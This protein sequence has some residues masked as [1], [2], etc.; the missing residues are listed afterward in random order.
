MV[1]IYTIYGFRFHCDLHLDAL[2]K[3]SDNHGIIDYPEIRIMTLQSDISPSIGCFPPL[4][5]AYGHFFPMTDSGLFVYKDK[6]NIY[7]TPRSLEISPQSFV[8]QRI[9]HEIC[10]ASLIILS[11]FHHRAVLHGS[12]VCY[13]GK[14][15]LFCALPGFGKSTLTAAFIAFHPEVFLLTDDIICIDKQ[16][17]YIF[18]GVS[19]VY[20][21]HD[22]FLFFNSMNLPLR[23]W[24]E[25][26]TNQNNDQKYML[27]VIE[28]AESTPPNHMTV[29]IG[30]V[31]FIGPPCASGLLQITPLESSDLFLETIKHMK[32]KDS[33]D[34]KAM[35]NELNAI[36]RLTAN[37][38]ILGAQICLERDYSLL[39]TIS[40]MILRYID[41][42]N[43]NTF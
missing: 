4:E 37:S 35:K 20:L 28:N 14:A 30:G 23:N 21:N 5:N 12:A 1:I 13:K 8:S 36:T 38:E 31:F 33:M 32:F 6:T 26:Q 2:S 3:Y 27:S 40:N 7:L 24:R 29:P 34:C 18:R 11:R 25:A 43:E 15:Y 17:R 16:G 10:G 41:E 9:Y 39:D 22:S 19:H 42:Q